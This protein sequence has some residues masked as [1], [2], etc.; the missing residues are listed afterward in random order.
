MALVK[1]LAVLPGD[2]IGQE[3]IPEALRVLEAIGQKTSVRF[4]HRRGLVGGA[5]IDQYG[6]PI[7]AE[8]MAM[9]AECDAILLGAVGGPRWDDLPLDRRPESALLALRK[10]F[11]CYANLRPIWLDPCLVHSIPLREDVVGRGVD[12]L[13]VRELAHGLY[14]GPRGRRTSGDGRLEAFD[15]AVYSEEAVERVARLAFSIAQKRRKH[16]VS[17][18]KSNILET[19]K[20]WREVVTRVS[21]AYPEVTVRHQLVDSGAMLFVLRPS[22]LDVVLVN[23]EFGDILSD[24]AAVLAGSLGMIPSAAIGPRH[25]YFY[26]PIHGS[27]PDIAGQAIANPIGAILTAAMM[28]RYSFSLEGE[29]RMVE[30]AV[31]DA[32]RAGCRTRDIAG[33]GEPTVSTERMGDAVVEALREQ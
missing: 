12:I 13:I 20:L 26:E 6:R 18:D 19:S 30:A 21:Q 22:D 7:T 29:A 25:P 23:N 10:A 9:C 15:T 2:G 14:Y 16:L 31:R 32:L 4:E 11:D 8:V 28:L 1:T 3:V 27:A 17:M 33:E 24:E 5:A